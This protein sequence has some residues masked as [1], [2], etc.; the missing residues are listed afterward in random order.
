M[1]DPVTTSEWNVNPRELS[2][3]ESRPVE[4]VW[5]SAS[6]SRMLTSGAEVPAREASR[7]RGRGNRKQS[8]SHSIHLGQDRGFGTYPVV[9]LYGS[10]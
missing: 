9:G 2:P 4:S 8:S 1:V 3:S 6:I 7:Q 5:E 10:W